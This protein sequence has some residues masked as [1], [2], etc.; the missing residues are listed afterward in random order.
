[1]RPVGTA[2]PLATGWFLVTIGVLVAIGALSSRLSGRFGVPFYLVFLAIGVLAGENGP[3]GIVFEGFGASYRLG[4]L[5]LVMILFDGGLNT[6]WA[7]VRRVAAPAATLATAGVAAIAGGTAVAARFCGLPW[8]QAV[9]VGAIV[10]STD[11]A[12][13]FAQ[14]RGARLR[15]RDRVAS[16]IEVESGVNDPMAVL[17]T[18]G[19]TAW[20][21]GETR[22]GLSIAGE[23]VQQFV[24]GGA[25]GFAVGYGA[26]WI[27]RRFRSET[28]GL[29]PVLTVA[30]A[31]VAYGLPTVLGGSG[32]L[33]VYLAGIALGSQRLPYRGSLVRVHD[34]AA[35]LS[36]VGMFL[37]LGLLI[38]PVDALP[39]AGWGV[40]VALA[41]TFVVRPAA[42]TAILLPFGFR[43]RE[44][45][46]IGWAGLRGAV[47][48]VLAIFPVLAGIAGGREVFNGVFFIVLVSAVLPG[49]TLP[50]AARKAR[51]AEAPAPVP[52]AVLEMISTEQLEGEIASFHIS[53][54]LAVAGAPIREVP[55]P[56][57]TSVLLVGRGSRLIPARG[58]TVLQP[59]DHVYLFFWE[60]DR[61]LIELLFGSADAASGT[62]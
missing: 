32:L 57:G 53:P 36:Q 30:T 43:W 1:M 39:A 27:L 54:A 23:L 10:S 28:A 8:S 15:L 7:T 55:L 13:V 21:A 3:G 40:G 25:C 45:F 42:V 5:A 41:L 18:V 12:T 60:R 51:L 34:A 17:L 61:P 20:L 6:S 33:A 46:F 49:A 56:E 11:A 48:I 50:W 47:P 14:L 22:G 44:A 58:S 26:S 38:S 59:G 4:M 24:L 29:Y 19:I 31:L 62:P 2:E 52:R 16:T 37:L 9:L 35:W